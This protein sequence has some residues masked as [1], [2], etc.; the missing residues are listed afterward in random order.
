MLEIINRIIDVVNYYPTPH[1]TFPIQ[2]ETNKKKSNFV[3]ANF[4]APKQKKI[5]A[6][7]THTL[8]IHRKNKFDHIRHIQSHQP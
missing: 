6:K 3:I 2:N 4:F 7:K 1:P 8:K 5:N